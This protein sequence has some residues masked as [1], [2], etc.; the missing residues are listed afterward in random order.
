[1]PAMSASLSFLYPL[2]ECYK[3]GSNPMANIGTILAKCFGY[4]RFLTKH[5]IFEI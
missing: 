2:P 3:T 4:V 1:M 5:A